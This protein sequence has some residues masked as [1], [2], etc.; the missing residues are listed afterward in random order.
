[1]RKG[2]NAVLPY[3]TGGLL[4]A[5]Q[6]LHIVFTEINS[7]GLLGTFPSFP[8]DTVAFSV[9]GI[10]LDDWRYNERLAAFKQIAHSYVQYE[11]DRRRQIRRSQQA[12][13]V[14][15]SYASDTRD[16]VEKVAGTL[17]EMKLEVFYDRSRQIEIWGEDLLVELEEIYRER[18]RYC[19]IFVSRQYT[20]NHWPK[21]ELR[22]A[23]ERERRAGETYIL[24]VL[25]EERRIDVPGLELSFRS[26][27]NG[28]E[29]GPVG[30]ASKIYLKCHQEQQDGVM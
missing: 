15:L 28:L 20:L 9:P 4:N 1:V 13:D 19:A 22:S 29:L 21:R 7:S 18:S 11:V 3:F 8:S 6:A 5:G 30:V 2:V 24:P 14:C 26:W 16:F 10:Y 27:L 17:Q 23:L 25:R 12:Y